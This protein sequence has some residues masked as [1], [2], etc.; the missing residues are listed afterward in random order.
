MSRRSRFAGLATVAWRESRTARR[1]LL[2]YMSSITLGVAALVAI[3]SFA[4]NAT[5][6]VHEQAR[7]LLGGDLSLNARDSFSTPVMRLFDTL[8]RV[9]VGVARRT[10]FASMVVGP[11]TGATRLV[12]VRAVTPDYPFYGVVETEPANA[13]AELQNSPT[14]VADVSLLVALGLKVGD[15][16]SLGAERF[17]L[18]GTIVSVPGEIAATATV[19]PRVYIADRYVEAT[20]LLVFGSRSEAEAVIK[21]PAGL[22]TGQFQGRY[23]RRLAAE[24]VRLHT[25]A[26]N[27]AQ[28]NDAIDQLRNFLSVVGLVALLLGGVGVASGVN[29]FVMRKIDTVAILRCLGATSWQVLIIYVLQAAAMGLVGAVAGTVLGIMGQFSVPHFL[30]SF[31]PPGVVVEFA[32]H[33]ALLGLAIGLWVALVFALRPL[34]GLRRVSP[35]QALRRDADAAVMRLVRRDSSSAI[36]SFAIVASVLGLTLSRSDRWQEGVGFATAVFLAVGVLWVAAAGLSW[37]ARRMVS[38]TWPF[39]LRH[40]VASLHRP[41]NQ[42]RTVVLSL[43]FGVFLMSTLY[44]VQTNLLKQ[45]DIRISALHANIVFFDVQGAQADSIAAIFATS[46]DQLLTRIPIINVRV[47]SINGRSAADLAAE[48]NARPERFGGSRAEQTG[49]RGRAFLRDWRSTYSDTLDQG[50][51]IVVGRWFTKN[52]ETIAQV[53]LDSAFAWQMRLRLGD[54]VVW[55]VQGV[56]VPSRVTSFRNVDRTRLQPTFPV[57]FSPHA[58]DAAPKQWVLLGNAPTPRDVALLQRA[59][60][61]AYP[62]VSSLDLTLV[63]HTIRLV[64]SKVTAAIR[65]MGLLSLVLAIP[66]LFSAVAATRRERLREAVLF[67]TLG[68]TRRQVG[69]ILLAEYLLLGA[70]GSLSGVLL[71]VGSA[72]ALA[73]F[74]F[75]VGFSPAILAAIGI[76]AAMT[77]VAV[78]IGLLT[79]RDVFATTPMAAL[80]ET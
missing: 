61:R 23:G 72:W 38:R 74:V 42:T 33:A 76:S 63:E 3:D 48:A 75:K 36:V 41:G 34:L 65:F 15:T 77:A 19:G 52:A 37:A 8:S 70:L 62:N 13:Y 60:V 14:A 7:T 80:R 10:T 2:L 29:A 44:Q 39:V 1:R 20:H 9:G 47:A 51:T 79:S 35:L 78:S 30:G 45:L 46:H 71:S 66:V 27:E 67:K 55:T 25:V 4:E 53:S 16:I 68:G 64:L 54:T 18:R 56:R 58:L 49:R 6:T 11:D 40:A 17:V 21:L 43:G 69:R 31:L 73:H 50:E 26:Q 32:P 5:A 22:S 57:I 12:Q 59:V 24:R 28:L